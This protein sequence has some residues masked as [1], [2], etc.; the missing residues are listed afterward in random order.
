M[1]KSNYHQELCH[2]IK[3]T[4]ST[5]LVFKTKMYF[6]QRICIRLNTK[7]D[8]NSIWRVFLQILST[9]YKPIKVYFGKANKIIAKWIIDLTLFC[10]FFLVISAKFLWQRVKM[11]VEMIL[12]W[13][14]IFTILSNE[15]RARLYSQTKIHLQTSF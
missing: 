8:L 4:K 14:I 2:L 15:R 6:E 13:I 10:L 7:I 11:Q 3:L 5:N 1:I 9:L 12:I